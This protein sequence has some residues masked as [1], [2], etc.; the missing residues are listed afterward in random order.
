LGSRYA[1][2][3]RSRCA[4]ALADNDFGLSAI[5]QCA[6]LFPPTEAICR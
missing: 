3:K 5:G 4:A 6:G 1:T 2:I